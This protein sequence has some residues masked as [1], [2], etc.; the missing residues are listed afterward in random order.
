[1]CN[2][3]NLPD[4]V[5]KAKA[6]MLFAKVNQ[7]DADGKV[8][9]VIV[10]GSN[11][12]QYQIIIRRNHGIMSTELLLV[13]NKQTVKPEFGAQI[14]Y[15]QLTAV[16]VSANEAGYTVNWTANREDAVRLSRIS[17]KVFHI[18]NF[19]NPTSVMWGVMKAKE[20]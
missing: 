10:P 20:K 4:R 12:K 11:G 16:M 19:D 8:K 15:H 5:E 2:K 17:G 7:Y 6:A 18:Y 14:T 1:M 3:T 9:S 13:V